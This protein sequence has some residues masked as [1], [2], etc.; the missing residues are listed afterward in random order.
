ML[1]RSGLGMVNLAT[2]MSEQDETSSSA[3]LPAGDPSIADEI[4]EPLT[5]EP[6]ETPLEAVRGEDRLEIVDVL[7]GLSLLGILAANMRGHN[8]P[9]ILYFNINSW[10]DQPYDKIAQ[11]FVNAFIQGK[12]I[13]IFSFLFGLG[14][15]VQFT[16][17]MERGKAV[18]GWF[19]R[20][21]RLALWICFAVMIAVPMASQLVYGPGKVPM[22]ARVPLA[23]AGVTVLWGLYLLRFRKMSAHD[24][25]FS[26]YFAKRLLL[27]Y[28][29]GWLHVSLLWWGDVLTQYA[30]AGFMLL[31]FRNAKL[32]T[33]AIWGWAMALVPIAGFTGYT[34]YSIFRPPT[35]PKPPNLSALACKVESANWLYSTGSPLELIADRVH[36]VWAMMPFITVGVAFGLMPCFLLGLWVW[37]KGIVENLEEW[38]PR[39]K[40][41]WLWLVPVALFYWMFGFLVPYVV[42]IP[43]GQVSVLAYCRELSRNGLGIF[44]ALF[45]VLSFVLAVRKPTIWAFFRPCGAIGRLSLSNYL[46]Q[47]LIGVLL[48]T[49]TGLAFFGHGIFLYGKIGPLLDLPITLVIYLAQIPLSQWYLRHYRIGPVEWLWRSL[50]YGEPQRFRR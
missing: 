24:R 21:L 2:P 48:F 16:R 25:E 15:A 26:G 17:G 29:L 35:I 45:Y 34:I 41:V 31:M 9:E 37:K 27:L 42:T 46:L 20:N 6:P 38:V 12:F 5:P 28:G 18:G 33:V 22:A 39:L 10:F 47:S 4:L 40:R 36:A 1:R 23:F 49:S 30:T 44:V 8:A 50:S 43:R 7:R 32:K 11:T 19:A 3:E 13:S 14:F